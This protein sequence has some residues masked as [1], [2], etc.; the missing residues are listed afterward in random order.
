[1][2][3]LAQSSSKNRA[4]LGDPRDNPVISLREKIVSLTDPG[5]FH[6]RDF[7]H[8]QKAYMALKQAEI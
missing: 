2:C 1:M 8:G 3:N 4:A 6:L 5:R 7:F